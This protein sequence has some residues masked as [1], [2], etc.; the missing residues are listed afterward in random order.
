MI[1]G[2]IRVP[3][4]QKALRD[5]LQRDILDMHLNGDE[6]VALGAAFR[7]ANVS[8]SFRLRF[9][10][11]SDICPF[12]IGMELYR[13]QPEAEPAEVQEASEEDAE[14]V[15]AEEP[16]LDAAAEKQQHDFLLKNKQTRWSRPLYARGSHYKTQRKITVQAY[17]DFLVHLAY[18]HMEELPEH[19][20]WA[21]GAR[22]DA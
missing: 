1:G 8:T 14:A 13:A 9:V 21:V 17:E 7:A 22:S 16:V 19:A 6:T 4:F 3:S 2:S 15:D 5:G 18:S 10:G 20:V 11:I 12:S